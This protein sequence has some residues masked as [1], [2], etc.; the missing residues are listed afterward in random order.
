[1]FR[2][3]FPLTPKRELRTLNR[4]SPLFRSIS[5]FALIAPSIFGTY[6][7]GISVCAVRDRSSSGWADAAPA[8]SSSNKHPIVFFIFSFGFSLV[9]DRAK[10][11]VPPFIGAKLSLNPH[12][13]NTF[14]VIYFSKKN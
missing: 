1:M 4:Y 6:E 10:R 3:T 8:A 5:I 2:L 7:T 12:S 11:S 14:L 9:Y 13:S